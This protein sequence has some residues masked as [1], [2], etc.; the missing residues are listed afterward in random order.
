YRSLGWGGNAGRGRPGDEEDPVR[1]IDQL[2]EGAVGVLQHA[3]V[4]EVEDHAALV[5]QTHDDAFAVD[6]GDDRDANI[7]LALVDAHL[8]AAV[9]R[10]ALLGDVQVRH[11]LDTA[12]DGCLEPVDFRRQRLQLQQAVD[13]VTDA[14][15][16]LFRFDVDVAG[17][18]V[19]RLD[20]DFID[21]LDDRGFLGHLGQLAV[22]GLDLFEEF[23]L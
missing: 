5:E 3:D 12:D 21:Q 15:A 20:E 10:Q 23:D 1:P 2:A 16:R 7:D 18:L 14:Q 19:G 8:D 6:H 17:A 22:V 4:G 13:A 9:L 11:D